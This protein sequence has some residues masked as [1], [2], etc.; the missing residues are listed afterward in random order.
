MMHYKAV[1]YRPLVATTRSFGQFR[2]QH[3]NVFHSLATKSTEE[4]QRK[5]ERERERVSES[6]VKREGEQDLI[7]IEQTLILTFEAESR[8]F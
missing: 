3:H 7:K 8:W 6:E 5:R 4:P 2:S 1:F